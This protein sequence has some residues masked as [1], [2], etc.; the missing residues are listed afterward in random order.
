MPYIIRKRRNEWLTVN[1]E[2]GRILGRHETKKKA[3]SQA[4]LVMA[5][6]HGWKP[7]GKGVK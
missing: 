5:R 6:E 4:R 1:A 3:E 7:S 2:T